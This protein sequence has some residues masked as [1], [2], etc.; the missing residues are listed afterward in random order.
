MTVK[1]TFVSSDMRVYALCSLMELYRSKKTGTRSPDV[2]KVRFVE[3]L[4]HLRDGADGSL[5]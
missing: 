5:F 3:R 1:H 4:D 2:Y